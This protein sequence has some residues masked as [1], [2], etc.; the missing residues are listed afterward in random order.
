VLFGAA[1]HDIG[2]TVHPGELSGPGSTHE[3]AGYQ[4]LLDHGVAETMARFA[5]THAA[6]TGPNIT[7]EDLLVSLADKIWKAKRVPDLEQLVLDRLA[8]AAGQQP[9]E[10]FL[11]LDTVLPGSP[12]TPT[13]G[14]PSKTAT[15]SSP[16]R[17]RLLL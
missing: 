17:P 16:D 2:K 1:T 11:A 6:W 15:R 12:K 5:R 4:L 14:S 13:T 7:I 3:Q 10:A 8:A 9:W